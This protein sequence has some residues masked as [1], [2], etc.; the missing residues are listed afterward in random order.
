MIRALALLLLLTPAALPAQDLPALYDVTG[1]AVN[2]VLNIRAEP[3][4]DAARLGDL[5]PD[6]ANVEVIQTADGW[7]LVN[8]GEGAGW[9]AM[10]F[11]APQAGGD[12]ALS[13]SLSCFGTEPF[14]SLDF[15][16]GELARFSSP[17]WGISHYTVGLLQRSANRTDRYLLQGGTLVAVIGRTACN[18]GMSDRRF[19]LSVDLLPDVEGDAGLYSGCCSLTGN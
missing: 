2:D 9:V 19:G 15:T 11:L 17:A 5:P 18:D 3:R 13:R 1:V 8:A 4:A 16:Q 14:W 6:A 12:Y 7:G 10:R